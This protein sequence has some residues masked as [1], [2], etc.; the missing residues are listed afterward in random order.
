MIPFADGSFYMN[1]YL[2]SK[3]AVVDAACFDY[4]AL[5]ATM[6][7]KGYIFDNIARGK[8]IPEE[9]KMCCCEIA[10]LLFTED[11]R[12]AETGG[13]LSESVGGWSKS[14]EGSEKAEQQLTAKIN[15]CIYKW[16]ANTGLLFCGVKPC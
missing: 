16:L 10:E 15:S 7:I 12:Q 2:C 11:K 8:K 9:V 4:Y 5:Q 3:Q 13:I 1:K 14:Y 6:K